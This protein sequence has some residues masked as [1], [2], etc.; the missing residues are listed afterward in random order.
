LTA[1]LFRTAPGRAGDEET[2]RDQGIVYF[3]AA[4]TA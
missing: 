1:N 2:V 3:I 4:P